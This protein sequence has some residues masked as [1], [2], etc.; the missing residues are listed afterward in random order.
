MA[1]N[2]IAEA[3]KSDKERL[4]DLL[5]SFGVGFQ[6]NPDH[7]TLEAKQGGVQGYVGF[8]CCFS[9]DDEGHFTEVSVYE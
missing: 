9:F 3:A 7:V 4:T 5:T 6:E 8:E 2:L 1:K